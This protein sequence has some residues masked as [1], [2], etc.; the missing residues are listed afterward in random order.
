MKVLIRGKHEKEK[1]NLFAANLI[2]TCFSTSTYSVRLVWTNIIVIQI[3]RSV[4]HFLRVN[5][6]L[7]KFPGVFNVIST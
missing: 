7:W 5:E 4:V 2:P 6:S 1:Y 3:N